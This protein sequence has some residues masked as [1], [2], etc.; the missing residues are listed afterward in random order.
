MKD[1]QISLQECERRMLEFIK[2][3]TEKGKSC[4][5]GNSVYTDKA[6]LMKY[7]PDFMQHL[8]YRIIDVTSIRRLCRRWYPKEY[9]SIPKKENTHRAL[10]DIKES[11]ERLRYYKDTI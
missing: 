1:S 5:A 9:E 8:H 3:H 4:L 6:F 7:M 2:K 10:Q 11:T